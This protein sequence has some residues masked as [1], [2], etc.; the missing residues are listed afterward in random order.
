MP[1]SPCLDCGKP[2]SGSRCPECRK[3][4]NRDVRNS[5][6][7]R[8]LSLEVRRRE[9]LCRD[10]KAA[11]RTTLATQVHHPAARASGGRLLPPLEE[12]IPLC[13]S[14]HNRREPRQYAAFKRSPITDPASG[15]SFLVG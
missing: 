12:L 2:C 3:T 13:T 5:R 10:C 14:C 1:Q 4:F 7:W 11:G 15:P 6:A 9:P 8:A